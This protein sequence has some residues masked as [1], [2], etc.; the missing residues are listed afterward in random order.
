VETP[1][2]EQARPEATAATSAE[3]VIVRLGG[4]RYALPMPAVAEVGRP[5]ALTRVPGVPSWVAG[6]AN[7]RGRVLAVLDLRPLLSA[8][9]TTLDRRGRLV[10]LTRAGVTAGLLTEGVEGTSDIDGESIEP[11]LANL[12]TMT[13]ALISG[14]VTDGGG[15][16]GVLDLDAV[17]GLADTLTRSRRAM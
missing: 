6:V 9:S 5:P 10:V 14:Q 12:P 2:S 1:A 11:S 13:G 15:P 16:V 4:C 8:E 3:V 17:F 7:W